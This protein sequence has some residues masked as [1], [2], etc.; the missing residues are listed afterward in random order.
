VVASPLLFSLGGV[1]WKRRE[2]GAPPGCGTTSI[3]A[4]LAKT[5]ME[6]GGCVGRG[7]GG[8]RRAPPSNYVE[9]G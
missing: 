7:E 1:R 5:P 9:K 3:Q 2:S 4:C 8:L 6:G